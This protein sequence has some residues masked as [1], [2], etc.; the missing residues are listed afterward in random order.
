MDANQNVEKRQV[1]VRKLVSEKI[2]LKIQCAAA[3]ALPP[4]CV[5]RQSKEAEED[6][7]AV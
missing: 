1:L 4:S 3:A 6:L 5:R 7:A 2:D